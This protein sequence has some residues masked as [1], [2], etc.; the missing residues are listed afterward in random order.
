MR[1]DDKFPLKDGKLG[2]S[3]PGV[4]YVYAQVKF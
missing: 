3:S 1:L 4:Y 2:V